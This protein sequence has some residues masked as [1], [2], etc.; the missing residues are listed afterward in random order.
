MDKLAIRNIEMMIEREARAKPE[1]RVKAA[2]K[3]GRYITM[4]TEDQKLC[5]QYSDEAARLM[6]KHWGGKHGI[7]INE[8]S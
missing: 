7:S 3:V 6:T 2:L 5:G 4:V 8:K 1:A